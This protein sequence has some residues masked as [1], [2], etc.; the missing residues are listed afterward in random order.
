MS[1]VID[2]MPAL[3]VTRVSRWIFNCYVI[4]D[5]DAGPVVVDAG[6]PSAAD[7]LSPVL[8][9]SSTPVHT[10]VATHGHSD[11]VAGAARLAHRHGGGIYLP[12]RTLDYLEGQRPRTPSTTKVAAIWPTIVGQPFDR[13]GAS[14]LIR[15]SRIAGFGTQRG[16]LWTGPTPA[17]PLLDGQCLPGHQRGASSPPPVTPTTASRCGTRPTAR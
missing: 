1:L 10:I 5:G 13:A 12:E 6:L 3:G 17:G 11:H 9:E 16:M 4:H 8:R 14:G 15:G 7:D 2:P